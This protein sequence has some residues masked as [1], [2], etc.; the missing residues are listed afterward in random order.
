MISI[1][2]PIY[3]AEKT[4]SKCLE[5]VVKQTYTNFELILIDDGSP[6]DSG[7]I[8]D[9]WAMIDKRICV[10]HQENKGVSAARN[11]G[12]EIAKGD[13]ICFVDPDDWVKPDYIRK[14]YDSLLLGNDAGVIIHGFESKTVDG[15]VLA[16]QKLENKVLFSDE[17]REI[18]VEGYIS[19]LGYSCSK[20][21]QRKLLYQHNIRFNEKI[22]CCEDL[23][24]LFEYIMY[25]DYIV[26]GDPQ[27]YMYI[28][29]PSSL[30]VVVNNFAAEY[31]CFTCYKLYIDKFKKKYS[32]TLTELE[33]L[34]QSLMGCFRRA[35]KTNYIHNSTVKPSIRMNDLKMLVN[36]N[37]EI[38]KTL[39][40]PQYK[41]DIIGA[42]LL[43]LNW[44][45]IFD[46]YTVCLYKLKIKQMY[47]SVA[48]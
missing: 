35:L 28:K 12:I 6:D 4:L 33:G 37:R 10:I 24:F 13:Y 34:N 30:S 2:I 15:C 47:L 27:E 48:N 36:E 38:I 40:H 19:K 14:M 17:F 20:L 32:L 8:C 26:C 25:C 18:L 45:I 7:T 31:E 43:K 42:F 41:L 9:Q 39:Y 11:H 23:L 16:G 29:Y 46:L 21:Y 3:K 44:L 1:I 5:S 22:H